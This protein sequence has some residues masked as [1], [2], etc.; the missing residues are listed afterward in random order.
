MTNINYE[1]SMPIVRFTRHLLR[2]FPQLREDEVPGN[3]VREVVDELD[4]RYPGLASYLTDD[5]GALR[6]HVNLFLGDQ[7]ILDRQTLS[8]PVTQD[9]NLYI[10]QALSGG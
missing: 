10:L 3:T 1:F 7:A 9:D 8:D 4:R 5:R 2:F 6:K